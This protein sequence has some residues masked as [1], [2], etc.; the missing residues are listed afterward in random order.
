LGPQLPAL[1]RGCGGEVAASRR[2]R[3]DPDALAAALGVGQEEAADA[4]DVLV[5][6]GSTSFGRSDHLGRV[7]AESG[8]RVLVRGVACRPGHPQLLARLSDGRWLVG[9][10]GNPLAALC[11]VVTLLAPLLAR[12]G[13][14]P[15]PAGRRA[16]VG[17]VLMAQPL[18]TRLVPVAADPL[19]RG[20]FP[21]DFG[22]SAMLRGIARA[23]GLAVVPPGEGR[24]G[25]VEV[26]PVPG[27]PAC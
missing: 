16:D 13:G 23:D 25:V 10:P 17:G 15:M 6:T 20:V 24:V 19:S 12:L 14:R 18:V 21:L 27:S 9:L 3:D 7:L 22:G 11:A 26:L 4:A 8:A 5:T 1:V 2:V